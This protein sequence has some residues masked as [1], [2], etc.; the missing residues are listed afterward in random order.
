MCVWMCVCRFTLD[1]FSL[2]GQTCVAAR[3]VLCV[4]S[5]FKCVNKW[6]VA[7]KGHTRERQETGDQ[8]GGVTGFGRAEYTAREQA[9][10][11]TAS[12]PR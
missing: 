9:A 7:C 11:V 3:V 2:P 6:P 5:A 8:S 10:K 12:Y 1:L 4:H